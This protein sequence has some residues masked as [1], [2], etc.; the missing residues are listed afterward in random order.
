MPWLTLP[1]HDYRSKKFKFVFNATEIP[2]LVFL[3]VKDATIASD[4]GKDLLL[5]MG[6]DA[7]NYLQF[8]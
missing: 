8:H 5:R 4:D 6:K 3:R 7:I 1:Y 2:K